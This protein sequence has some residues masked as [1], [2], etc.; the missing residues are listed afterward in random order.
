MGRTQPL[1]LSM[2]KTAATTHE[3]NKE[4]SNDKMLPGSF[5]FF[6]IRYTPNTVI[7]V[8]SYVRVE[9]CSGISHGAYGQSRK[10]QMAAELSNLRILF[11]WC[12]CDYSRE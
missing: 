9:F 6:N 1:E 7:L 8:H 2:Q 3:V 5:F 12:P 4:E 10:C 11:S